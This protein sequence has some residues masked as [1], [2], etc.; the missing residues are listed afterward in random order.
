MSELAMSTRSDVAFRRVSGGGRVSV[1]SRQLYPRC[2][3]IVAFYVDIVEDD[4]DITTSKRITSYSH[5]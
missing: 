2:S 3:I 5:Q 4:L 1:N